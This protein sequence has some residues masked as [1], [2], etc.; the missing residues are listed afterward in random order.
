[1]E[2]YVSEFQVIP[3]KRFLSRALTYI[4]TYKHTSKVKTVST[5]MHYVL[6]VDNYRISVAVR[7]SIKSFT[8]SI[9]LDINFISN[10]GKHVD[11]S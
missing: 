11:S 10:P 3:I 9:M 5:P 6:G 7:K 1:M 4:Q 8:T 2:Y